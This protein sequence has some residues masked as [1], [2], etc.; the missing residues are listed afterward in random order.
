MRLNAPET[1]GVPCDGQAVLD[2]IAFQL[3]AQNKAF[4]ELCRNLE[5][6]L[7]ESPFNKTQLRSTIKK[8]IAALEK[9]GATVTM[10]VAFFEKNI[11]RAPRTEGTCP[12]VTKL[13]ELI[14]GPYS[15]V[16]INNREVET[17]KA[18]GMPSPLVCL[19]T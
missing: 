1:I 12:V 15:T 6:L 13:K 19:G 10:L 11:G 18:S 2:C 17:L 3:E 14:R 4:N 16:A 5:D 7:Q 8:N 9:V